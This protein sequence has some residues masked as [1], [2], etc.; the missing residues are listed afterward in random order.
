MRPQA[1]QTRIEVAWGLNG[2]RSFLPTSDVVVIVDVLS[3]STAVDVAV[4]R[5]AAILPYPYGELSAAAFAE[6]QSAVLA[7]PRQTGG[8]QLSLSPKSLESLS[9]GARIVLPSPNGSMLSRET[10]SVATLAGCLRNASAIAQQALSL[11][12]SIAV[13]A[14]GERWP[15]GG[16]RPALED[17][18]GVGAIVD[19]LG[20]ECSPEAEAICAGYRALR[21]KLGEVIQALPSGQE[22]IQAGFAGD[23]ALA[24]EEDVSGSV[25]MLCDGAY[26]DATIQDCNDV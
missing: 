1:E 3:F 19:R 11:G 12:R 6:Q 9:P 13:I 25:P 21:G 16:L 17:L 22:L 7:Q 15:D 23:V 8:G 2:L 5:G 18:L 14:A 4:G 20:R 26:R 24:V 10:G